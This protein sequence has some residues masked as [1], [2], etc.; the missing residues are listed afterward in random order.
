MAF[1]TPPRGPLVGLPSSS[2]AP[3]YVWDSRLT[4]R[5]NRTFRNS[6][7]DELVRRISAEA[8]ARLS[9][10]N[11]VPRATSFQPRVA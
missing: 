10:G 4:S 11:A 3:V 6:G 2:A 5:E 9:L 7:E 8:T 1:L